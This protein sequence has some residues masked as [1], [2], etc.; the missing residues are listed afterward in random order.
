[1]L[2]AGLTRSEGS[3]ELVPVLNACLDGCAVVIGVGETKAKSAKSDCG[4][5]DESSC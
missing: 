1:M 2:P 5:D 3:E 4:E